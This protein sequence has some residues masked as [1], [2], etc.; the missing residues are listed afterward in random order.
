M[1]KPSLSDLIKQS[2]NKSEYLLNLLD[3]VKDE[4]ADVRKGNYS[5]EARLSAIEAIDKILYNKIKSA[6]MHQSEGE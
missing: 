1:N 4:I 6:Y 5:A 3:C 2:V